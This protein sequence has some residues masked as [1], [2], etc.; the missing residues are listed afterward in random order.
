MSDTQRV[1]VD[2]LA[3]QDEII[4]FLERAGATSL[5]DTDIQIKGMDIMKEDHTFR[6]LHV[7]M[8]SNGFDNIDVMF[9]NIN[10]QYQQDL[11]NVQAIL[12]KI[13]EIP[14]MIQAQQSVEE[15][16]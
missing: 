10:R 13:E 5:T 12:G 3:I 2:S 11:N 15:F 9:R 4:S 1:E 6:T 16:I 8:R 7:A 14:N